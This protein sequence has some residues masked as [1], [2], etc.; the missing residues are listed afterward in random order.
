MIHRKENTLSLRAIAPTLCVALAA[1]LAGCVVGADEGAATDSDHVG[2]QQQS[3][4]AAPGCTVCLTPTSLVAS[5]AQAE[6]PAAN[7]ADGSLA[8]RSRAPT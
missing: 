5:V 8:T 3:P 6:N 7:V 1:V 2:D 4:I